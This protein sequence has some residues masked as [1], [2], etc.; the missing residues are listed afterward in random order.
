[1]GNHKE[2]PPVEEQH[3]VAAKS[4][5][6]ERNEPVFFAPAATAGLS[7]GIREFKMWQNPVGIA[8]CHCWL[9]QQC[10]F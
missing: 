9:A 6:E 3:I 1:M 10:S 5:I 8:G 7:E 2:T 4:I